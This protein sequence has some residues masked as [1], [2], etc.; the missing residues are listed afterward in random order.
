MCA[1]EGRAGH[2][3]LSTALSDEGIEGE[4]RKE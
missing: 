4:E 2:C 1:C 3:E